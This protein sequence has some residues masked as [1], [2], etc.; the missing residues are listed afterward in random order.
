MCPKDALFGFEIMKTNRI[1]L[2][3]AAVLGLCC[4]ARVQAQP[5]VM[6][7]SGSDE[8]HLVVTT[9]L[10]TVTLSTGGVNQG[11]W[12]DGGEHDPGNTNHATGWYGSTGYNSFYIFDPSLLVGPATGATLIL[13]D[14]FPDAD[15]G[16]PPFNLSFWDV[17]TSANTLLNSTGDSGQT[18]IDLGSGINYGSLSYGGGGTITVTLNGNAVNQ[19][20]LDETSPSLFA[21]GVHLDSAGQVPDSGATFS[22]LGMGLTLLLGLRR[23]RK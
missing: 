9:S 18:Y 7:Y 1:V 20:N 8:N 14:Y 23:R 15:Y 17:T 6:G 11:W 22:L 13:N 2:L 4:L 12:A 10:G 16:T 19:I 5:F 21:V 3:F